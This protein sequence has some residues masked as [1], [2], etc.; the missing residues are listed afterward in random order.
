MRSTIQETGAWRLDIKCTPTKYGHDLRLIS[1]V[2]T[3][4]RPGEHTRLQATLTDAE[5]QALKKF[6]AAL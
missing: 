5:L 3:A 1:F 2:P 4:R 6:F